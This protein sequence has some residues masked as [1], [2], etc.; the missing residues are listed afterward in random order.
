[1]IVIDTTVLIDLWRGRNGVKKCLEKNKDELPCISAIT[2]EEIYDGL[3]YTKEKKAK[4]IYEK[5]KDQHEKI[6]KDFQVLP[7]SSNILKKAGLV[8]GKL[9]AKGITLDMAD[10]IIAITAKEIN[11]SKI[12]TR[13]PNHF[14]HSSVMVESY[15]TD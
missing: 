12:L 14:K 7:V 8:R 5:I 6:L 15:E 13:N 11:A 1:M 10:I 2:L 9:R 3:G 4:S